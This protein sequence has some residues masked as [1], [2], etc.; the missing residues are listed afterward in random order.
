[1]DVDPD[2]VEVGRFETSETK[3]QGQR[4]DLLELLPQ[5]LQSEEIMGSEW[6]TERVS[7]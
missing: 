5:Y 2:Y 3:A 1:M 7:N 4:V 6:F